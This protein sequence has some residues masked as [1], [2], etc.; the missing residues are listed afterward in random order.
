MIFKKKYPSL[1]FAENF[2][3]GHKTIGPVTIYGENAM[4][5]AVNIK[6]R[7]WGYVCFR[8]PFRCF[9]RWW[10]LYFYCSPDAT[11]GSS[12]VAVG[13][14]FSKTEKLMARIRRHLFGHNFRYGDD[15][16]RWNRDIADRF[17][18]MRI[19]MSEYGEIDLND[20][21]LTELP[22]HTHDRNH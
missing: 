5:W 4:H 11:P 18:L 6:T 20:F 1:S 8:L 15:F 12:T 2:L 7:R 21:K 22:R 13:P 19:K 3:G 14:R 16:I 10:P 9:G 17:D